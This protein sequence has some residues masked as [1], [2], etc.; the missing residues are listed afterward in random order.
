MKEINQMAY[1][2]ASEKF[3]HVDEAWEGSGLTS[4]TF[5]DDASV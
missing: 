3:Y 2:H 4:L 5:K 1:D